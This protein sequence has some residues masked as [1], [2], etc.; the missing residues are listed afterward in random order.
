MLWYLSLAC[1][2]DLGLLSTELAWKRCLCCLA[3]CLECASEGAKQ[4]CRKESCSEKRK[5]VGMPQKA[6]F[7][8]HASCDSHHRGKA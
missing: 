2:R 3:I 1:F 7:F 6:K 4:A 5:V 8:S